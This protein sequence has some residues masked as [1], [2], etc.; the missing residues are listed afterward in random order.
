MKLL[1]I[2]LTFIITLSLLH[3]SSAQNNFVFLVGTSPSSMLNV[4]FGSL[5]LVY[6]ESIWI[7][8]NQNL[9]I[10]L[11]NPS[12]ILVTKTFYQLNLKPLK[13]YYFSS[14]SSVGKWNLVALNDQNVTILKYSFN[15]IDNRLSLRNF[16][17]NSALNSKSLIFNFSSTFTS[18]YFRYPKLYAALITNSSYLNESAAKVF[19]ITN[20]KKILTGSLNVN[21]FFAKSNAS[22]IN[23]NLYLTVSY[24]Q[25]AT[26][27]TN[28]FDFVNVSIISYTIIMNS[29]QNTTVYFF[30]H[31]NVL[32]KIVRN[33]RLGSNIT[34]SL[35]SSIVSSG[36]IYLNVTLMQLGPFLISNYNT[37]FL[38]R[39]TN[40]FLNIFSIINLKEL[41]YTSGIEFN[42][43]NFILN[44]YVGINYSI[45]TK[46]F[47]NNESDI[48]KNLFISIIA[49]ENNI[50]GN[51]EM[52]AYYPISVASFYNMQTNSYLSNFTLLVNNK[53][54]PYL[55]N[56]FIILNQTFKNYTLEMNGETI[57]ANVLKIDQIP[58]Q[59]FSWVKIQLNL[60]TI[61]VSI[62]AYQHP[63]IN[64]SLVVKINNYTLFNSTLLSGI[65]TLILPSGNYT[66]K[67]LAKGYYNSSKSVYINSNYTLN[68]ALQSINNNSPITF[69]VYAYIAGIIVEIFVISYLI[70]KIYLDQKGKSKSSKGP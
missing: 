8:S 37:T 11:F 43:T 21:T 48:L 34:L 9:K 26:F 29:F 2:L 45:L 60:Y 56:N 46:F 3:F 1:F 6:G 14:N 33:Y 22:S 10:E 18:N 57:P 30:V 40:Q 38:A 68:F 24:L 49:E 27:K 58:F 54:Y 32:S 50:I 4:T 59:P 61:N 65:T 20:N 52:Q 36:L 28:T 66:F 17:L 53:P 44:G 15:L 70:R 19:L 62:S 35:N 55:Y 39:N 69:F 12:G 16:K 42:G 51:V 25:N 41:N 47:I 31:G 67:A 7:A 13:L 23:L 5:Q 64:S 63:I